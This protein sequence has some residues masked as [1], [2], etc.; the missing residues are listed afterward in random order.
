MQQPSLTIPMA[1]NPGVPLDDRLI[2][3]VERLDSSRMLYHSLSR[4]LC[5]N[6]IMASAES[7]DR[8]WNGETV[9][10]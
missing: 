2:T 4:R 10:R 5:T 9:D 7:D 8:C 1:P 6:G 3:F